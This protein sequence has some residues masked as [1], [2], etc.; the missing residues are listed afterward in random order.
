MSIADDPRFQTDTGYSMPCAC[1]GASFVIDCRGNADGSCRR[2]R[3]C[4]KCNGRF[5]TYE[6]RDGSVPPPSRDAL[7]VLLR[8]IEE[9]AARVRKMI[10]EAPTVTP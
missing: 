4:K 10:G 2:R 7:C 5:T 1:G 9:S 8:E 3:V 6:R